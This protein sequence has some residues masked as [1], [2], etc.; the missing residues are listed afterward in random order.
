MKLYPPLMVL[1]GIMTQL[2]IGYIAPVEPI[3]SET[4]Q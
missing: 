3:L 4:W 2:L 1:A